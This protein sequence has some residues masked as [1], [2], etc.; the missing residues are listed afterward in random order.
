MSTRDLCAPTTPWAPGLATSVL[1]AFRNKSEIKKTARTASLVSPARR[2]VRYPVYGG[3]MCRSQEGLRAVWQASRCE[4]FEG[5]QHGRS[6]PE[7][8]FH[9]GLRGRNTVG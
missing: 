7:D 1:T 3:R 2:D 6:F 8:L 5:F 9:V 4:E